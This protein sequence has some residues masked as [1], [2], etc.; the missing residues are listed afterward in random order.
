[1]LDTTACDA[2]RAMLL[3]LCLAW[4]LV[5]CATRVCWGEARSSGFAEPGK[6]PSRLPLAGGLWLR[7]GCSS[8]ESVDV[9]GDVVDEE[10]EQKKTISKE[11]RRR[12]NREG[13]GIKER[14]YSIEEGLDNSVR[15]QEEK[16]S[17]SSSSIEPEEQI[18]ENTIQA[19]RYCDHCG[20]P[21]EYCAYVGCIK[22]KAMGPRGDNA[23]N[24]TDAKETPAS[25]SKTMQASVEALGSLS[26]SGA[27]PQEHDEVK[28][29]LHDK[30]SPSERRGH[31]KKAAGRAKVGSS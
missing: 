2:P 19:V 9:S 26:L 7:G 8:N 24:A 28:S 29:S 3:S 25:V 23:V 31:S 14:D 22:G 11:L 17:W 30:P 1:M 10:K 21:S 13:K 5:G 15:R 12:G 4:L 6:P 18:T 27:D 16:G 20:V